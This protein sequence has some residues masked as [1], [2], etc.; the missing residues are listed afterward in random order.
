MLYADDILLLT[1][2]L[3][4]LQLM[5]D[6]CFKISCDIAV[7]F[8]VRKSHCMVIGKMYKCNISPNASCTRELRL[9][10]D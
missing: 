2:S 10:L 9:Y 4:G 7:Q 6:K 1:P 3:K 8:N 5:L